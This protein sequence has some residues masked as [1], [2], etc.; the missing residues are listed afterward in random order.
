MVSYRSAQKL[1]LW[2]AYLLHIFILPAVLGLL[3]NYRKSKQYQSIEYE[4]DSEDTIPV[5]VFLSHHLWM[6]R[7]FTELLILAVVG[8]AAVFLDL[9][10]Y[11]L[12]FVLIWWIYRNLRGILSL[13]LNKP[14]PVF[15]LKPVESF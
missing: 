2:L 7:S 15:V 4:D 13:L 14:M 3:I 9:G 10:F 1:T 6:M 5:G 11:G 12:V 8:G